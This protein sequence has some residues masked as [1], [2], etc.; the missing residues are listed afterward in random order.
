MRKST[1]VGV[2]VCLNVFAA[3]GGDGTSPQPTPIISVSLSSS[4]V[5]LEGVDARQIEVRVARGGGYTGAIDL[6]LE[7]APTGVTGSF[8]P[9]SVGN[10]STRSTLVLAVMASV[11]PGYY[12]LTI[13]DTGSGVTATTT[14]LAL[15]VTDP[16]TFGITA[17]PTAISIIPSQTGKVTVDVDRS[18]GFAADVNLALV[19][20][21]G[22]GYGP[23]PAGISATFSP[24][25]NTSCRGCDPN[26]LPASTM[27]LTVGAGV[28]PG[29]YYL[30]VIG[31]GYDWETQPAEAYLAVTVLAPNP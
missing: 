30:L 3:C 23:P 9:S 31:Y 27:I 18:G 25:P 5:I 24:N 8:S 13:R 14:S 29:T 12:P 6:E 7:G 11:T 2:L 19:T 1:T 4:T 21:A 16:G 17:D 10:G 26:F 20:R 15:T 28:A 22:S